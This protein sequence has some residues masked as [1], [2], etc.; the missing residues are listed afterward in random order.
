[1][2]PGSGTKRLRLLAAVVALLAIAGMH[3]L[4]TNAH[5]CHIASAQADG[6]HHEEGHHG[7]EGH[8]GAGSTTCVAVGC[9]A[10][11]LAATAIVAYGRRPRGVWAPLVAAVT[12]IARGPEPPVP[13]HLLSV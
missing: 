5:S 7:H 8:H 1:M 9:V 13:R 3:V 4:D 6:G 2:V 10:I 11:V 12:S